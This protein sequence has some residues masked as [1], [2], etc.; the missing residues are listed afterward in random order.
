MSCALRAGESEALGAWER[1][2]P[3][4]AETADDDDGGEAA[5]A[6]RGAASRR[7]G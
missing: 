3:M 1:A 5:G 2:V 4:E 7:P 6:A